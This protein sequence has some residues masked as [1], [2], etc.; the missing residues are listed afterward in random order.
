M[1]A[2]QDT[3]GFVFIGIVA[4]FSALAVLGIWEVLAEDVIEK[5]LMTIGLLALVAIIVMIAGRFVGRGQPSDI[6]IVVPHPAFHMIR[7]LMIGVLIVAVSLLALLGVMAIWD[8]IE[9]KEVLFK[10][11]TSI[12]VLAF[13]AF[14]VVI[15]CLE[16]EG[17]SPGTRK[18]TLGGF[19]VALIAMWIFTSLFGTLMRF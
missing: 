15:T 11:L 10:S 13:A 8:V 4:L 6:A 2:L 18:V 7:R 19:L 3:V 17:T 14:V 1:K 16:R 12:A 5:S 9:E